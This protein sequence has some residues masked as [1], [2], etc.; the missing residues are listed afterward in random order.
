METVSSASRADGWHL[1]GAGTY[2]AL[3]SNISRGNGGSGGRVL[4]K[5]HFSFGS[6]WGGFAAITSLWKCPCHQPMRPRCLE[7]GKKK[8][9][10][11]QAWLLLLCLSDSLGSVCYFATGE[12]RIE[13]NRN[14][15][16]SSHFHHSR[17]IIIIIKEKKNNS[18][19]HS[20]RCEVGS[21]KTQ[22]TAPEGMTPH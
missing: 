21:C 17:K 19:K 14:G 7:G 2:K 8:Q 11:L 15:C 6:I 9:T 18:K 22:F 4:L 12:L 16:D 3:W 10:T 1:Q 20:C 5:A 13:T